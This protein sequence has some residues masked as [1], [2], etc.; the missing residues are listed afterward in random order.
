MA[1]QQ[2]NRAYNISARSRRSDVTACRSSRRARCHHPRHPDRLEG[3]RERRQG[4]ILRPSLL[5]A[6]PVALHGDLAQTVGNLTSTSTTTG[7]SPPHRSRSVTCSTRW[8]AIAR[9]RS[10]RS[11][12][13][14]RVR[15]T[16]AGARS[17]SKW[18]SRSSRTPQLVDLANTLSLLAT[19][20]EP[21]LGRALRARPAHRLRGGLPVPGAARA[22]TSSSSPR[23]LRE[24][25]RT[26]TPERAG[27]PRSRRSQDTNDPTRTIYT[28]PLDDLEITRGILFP[29]LS[30][31]LPLRS[32]LSSQPLVLARSARRRALV[33]LANGQIPPPFVDA[34][35]DGLA[36]SRLER[37]T[38]SRPTARPVPSPFFLHRRRSTAPARTGSR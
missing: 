16:S 36:G 33:P 23:V 24:E 11:R 20:L 31:T 14:T 15:D 1:T 5:A 7:R 27:G 2:A 10:P 25:M 26:E 3:P 19:R 18:R 37:R 29:S 9:R 38:L 30:S 8:Q 22:G 28:R 34:D 12:A 13:W 21:L 35:G 4:P 6:A 32:S 17:R